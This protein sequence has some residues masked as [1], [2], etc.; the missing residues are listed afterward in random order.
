VCCLAIFLRAVTKTLVHLTRGQKR[1]RHHVR[2]A[3][4]VPIFVDGDEPRATSLRRSGDEFKTVRR[5]PH[6]EEN[7]IAAGQETSLVSL[8]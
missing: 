5:R 8:S 1:R 3:L 4:A 6:E 2:T 7:L